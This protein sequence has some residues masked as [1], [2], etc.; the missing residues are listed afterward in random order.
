MIPDRGEW[1]LEGTHR[2]LYCEGSFRFE[3]FTISDIDGGFCM[4]ECTA[5]Y[6]WFVLVADRK[7]N[8]SQI[9][10][11]CRRTVNIPPSCFTEDIP[12]TQSDVYK[13]RYLNLNDDEKIIAKNE[14]GDTT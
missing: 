5:G 9:E 3:K 4:P 10:Q 13:I 1:Q 11:F 8:H 6:N 12:L 2:C 7:H 14:I